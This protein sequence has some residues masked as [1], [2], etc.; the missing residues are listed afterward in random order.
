MKSASS[1]YVITGGPSAG[2]TTLIEALEARGMNIQHESARIIID[3]EIAAGKTVEEI[4]ADEELFQEIVYYHKVEREARLHQKETIFF[5]RGIPDTYAYNTL[6]GFAISKEMQTVMDNVFYKRVFLLEPYKYEK[7]YARVETVE[8]RDKLFGLLHEG[9]K[10]SGVPIE[11]V[12]AFPT[13]QERIEYFLDLLIDKEGISI[14]A[15]A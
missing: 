15:C 6:H 10:R 1:W 3:D 5:D 11:V 2:K 12:P 9:Y 8:E 4:R 7:D 14:P 13:K